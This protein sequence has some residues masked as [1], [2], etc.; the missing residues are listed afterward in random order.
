MSGVSTPPQ[1][2]LLLD[3]H[4]AAIVTH[5]AAD[6]TTPTVRV[7]VPIGAGLMADGYVLAIEAA[8]GRAGSGTTATLDVRA[9][10]PGGIATSGVRLGILTMAGT[11]KNARGYMRTVC[12]S[13]G[14][15]LAGDVDNG[16]TISS[17]TNTS[18]AS[19]V[20]AAGAGV[21]SFINAPWD[22]IFV[23]FDSVATAFNLLMAMAE[24][25]RNAL[26]TS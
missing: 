23:T 3:L 10:T 22:L 25:R 26:Q 2:L 1:R 13:S 8:L 21:S 18:N 6:A 15:N 24:L 14:A 17:L 16:S 5:S 7:R 12:R 20:T 4:A 11:G 9:T 19:S